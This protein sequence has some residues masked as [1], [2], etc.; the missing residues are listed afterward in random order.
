MQISR[1]FLTLADRNWIGLSVANALTSDRPQL[2]CQRGLCTAAAHGVAN[3][4]LAGQAASR[5]LDGPLMETGLLQN[6]HWAYILQGNLIL[7]FP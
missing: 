3:K 5:G 2:Y 1:V 6:A 7:R 4:M